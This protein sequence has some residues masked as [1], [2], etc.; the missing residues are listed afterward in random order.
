MK[1]LLDEC[2]PIDFRHK[3]SGHEVHTSEWAGFKGMKNGKLLA[4]AESAGYGVFLTIDQGIPYQQNLRPRKISI[5]VIRSLTNQIEDLVPI[6][7]TI[8]LQLA[9]IQS[10]QILFTS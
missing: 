5:I 2:L 7:E 8:L 10:G 4:E 9:E 1:I 6:V 3:L